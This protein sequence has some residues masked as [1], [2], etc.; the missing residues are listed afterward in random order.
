[1]EEKVLIKSIKRNEVFV[2]ILSFVISFFGMFSFL[3]CCLSIAMMDEDAIEDFLGGIIIASIVAGVAVA[4]VIYRVLKLSSLTVTDKRIY[5]VKG[6]GERVDLPIDSISSVSISNASKGVKVSTSSGF[7]SFVWLE[8]FNEIY[9]VI[10][11]VLIERQQHKEVIITSNIPLDNTE[12]LRKYKKLV[13]DGLIS[14]EEYEN[15][16]KE[17]LK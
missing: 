5:G 12:M 6:F 11:K 3:C 14:Q 13:D 9:D 16:K 7:I 2:T 15:K 1:M 8:N 4:F 17:L 10:N